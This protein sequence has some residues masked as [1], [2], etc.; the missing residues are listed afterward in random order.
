[1]LSLADLFKVHAHECVRT[2][3]NR[4]DLK[5][6]ATLLTLAQKHLKAAATLE[7]WKR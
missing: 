2:A 5:E 6:V 3:L 1:M 4:T 7:A